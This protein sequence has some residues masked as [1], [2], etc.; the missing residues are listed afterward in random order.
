MMN[1]GVPIV[2]G[3][4]EMDVGTGYAGAATV[5][6][7]EAH[8]VEVRASVADT[9]PAASILYVVSLCKRFLRF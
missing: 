4:V 9:T 3:L 8:D 1:F 6:C 5:L 2:M 7:A